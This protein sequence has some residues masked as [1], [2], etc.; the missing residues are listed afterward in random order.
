[1]INDAVDLQGDD[2]NKERSAFAVINSNGTGYIHLDFKL[3]RTVNWDDFL[4]ELPEDCPDLKYFMESQTFDGGG[5]WADKKVSGRRIG[6]SNL[7]VNT[8]YI[9]DVWGF[10]GKEEKGTDSSGNTSTYS[11]VI[12]DCLVR[13]NLVVFT[14]RIDAKKNTEIRFKKVFEQSRE[15]DTFIVQGSGVENDGVGNY[16]CSVGADGTFR[17]EIGID[18]RGFSMGDIGKKS[19]FSLV[20]LLPNKG[21]ELRVD[22]WN[23]D[24]GCLGEMC[25]ECFVEE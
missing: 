10:F 25:R 6:T 16:I 15:E 11:A 8:R 24:E 9:V 13:D 4:F 20:P 3:T 14:Y 18:R 2:S 12:E 21:R 19:S 1:M 22:T 5:V 17:I 23:G 7:R